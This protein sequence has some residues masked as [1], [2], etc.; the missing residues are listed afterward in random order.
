MSEQRT[1]FGLDGWLYIC[2]G[3]PAIF[4]GSL[5]ICLLAGMFIASFVSSMIAR[6]VLDYLP[7]AWNPERI[8][9]IVVISSL[10]IAAAGAFVFAVRM[11]RRMAK[12]GWP[13]PTDVSVHE[14][15]SQDR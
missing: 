7:A 10:V 5:T 15:E 14:R 13:M 2:I 1:K 9:I 12:A 6:Y 8:D 3:I 4:F 11:T